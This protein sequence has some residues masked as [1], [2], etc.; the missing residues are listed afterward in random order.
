MPRPGQ[1]GPRLA[2]PATSPG[3]SAC[4]RIGSCRDGAA[5]RQGG[6]D[7]RLR[8]R[9]RA[10]RR[11]PVRR[12]GCRRGRGRRRGRRRGRDRGPRRP[13]RVARPWRAS[14]MSRTRTRWRRSCARRPALGGL[15]VL[16]NNA[17]IFPG[18]DGGVLDTPPD[19]WDRVMAVNLKGVWL[20][21]RAA[22]PAMLDSRR[23]VDRQRGLLRGAHGRGHRAG[24]LHRVEGRGARLHPRAGGGVRPLGHPGQRPV[25]GAHRD[26]A[27]GGPAGGPRAPKRRLVHIPMGRLGRPEEVARAACSWR[28]TSPRS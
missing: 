18:D 9:H 7:H 12:R 1:N 8:Q 28:P 13:R 16:F 14:P 20:C 26:P 25:P 5:R 11:R 22:I 21:C 6:G 2:R 15:H 4:R 17:G 24:R 10:R 19:T 27:A 23:R 3:A